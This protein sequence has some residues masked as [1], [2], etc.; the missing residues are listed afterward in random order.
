M[1]ISPN[2]IYNEVRVSYH[3]SSLPDMPAYVDRREFP[4]ARL[5]WHGARR[6]VAFHPSYEPLL[7]LEGPA[8]VWNCGRVLQSNAGFASSGGK[9]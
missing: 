7:G 3:I 2:V 5:R 8:K 4:V 9:S 6:L 1:R